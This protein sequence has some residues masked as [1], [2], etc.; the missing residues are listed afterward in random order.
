MQKISIINNNSKFYHHLAN[1]LIKI[2]DF[3]SAEKIQKKAIEIEPLRPDF[4]FQL[5][6]IYYKKNDIKKSL[7]KVNEAIKLKSDNP[8]F[9]SHLATLLK[10]IG[11]NEGAEIARNKA[12]ELKKG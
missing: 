9:Y 6:C 1:I 7:Q 12:S 11:D 3:E 8:K 2:G 10:S 4:V 5:S